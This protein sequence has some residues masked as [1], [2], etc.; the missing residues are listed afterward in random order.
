MQKFI[1]EVMVDGKKQ[2]TVV[3]A[4]D[5]EAAHNILITKGWVV[6]SIAPLTTL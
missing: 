5:V 2:N 4:V 6:L 3:Q 1:C